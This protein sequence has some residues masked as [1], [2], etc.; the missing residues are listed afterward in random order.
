MSFSSWQLNRAFALIGILATAAIVS[1][2][3]VSIDKL[4]KR[5]PR[6]ET[7][8]KPMDQSVLAELELLHDPITTQLGS[9]VAYHNRRQELELSRRLVERHPQNPWAHCVRGSVAAELARFPEAMAEFGAAVKLQPQFTYAHLQLG[10]VEVIQQHFATAIPHFKR[11]VELQPRAGIGWV[12]LSG[13][14]EKL[15]RRQQSLEYAQRGIAVEPD[16][17]GTWLQLA[18]A[19]NALGHTENAKRALARGQQLLARR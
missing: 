6:P 10:A 4:L 11:V 18:H 19:E 2:Q 14:C 12:F 15:G 16:F 5:L 1:A 7:L 3:D 17:A 13:C 8:V 9:A